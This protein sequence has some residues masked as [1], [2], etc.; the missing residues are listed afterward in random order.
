MTVTCATWDAIKS[1]EQGVCWRYGLTS[2]GG[3]HYDIISASADEGGYVTGYARSG[4]TG[5]VVRFV[6]TGRA[7]KQDQ[8]RCR[9][10]FATDTG[11]AAGTLAF[12][13]PRT[14]DAHS[15]QESGGYVG[16]RFNVGVLVAARQTR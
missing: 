8:L 11:D 6:Q 16:G 10:E 14:E 4:R 3:G 1:S 12:G 7:V 15:G 13:L 5:Q 2:D 9:I